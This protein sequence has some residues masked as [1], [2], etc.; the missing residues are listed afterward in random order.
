MVLPFVNT[1]PTARAPFRRSVERLHA[2]GV[3]VLPGPGRSEPHAPGSGADSTGAYPWHPA[4]SS[5]KNPARKDRESRDRDSRKKTLRVGGR[6]RKTR[7][8]PELSDA[9]ARPPAWASPDCSYAE[10]FL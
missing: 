7:S 1:A 10:L 6:G 5:L 2:E 3:R 4:L 8:L 9:G